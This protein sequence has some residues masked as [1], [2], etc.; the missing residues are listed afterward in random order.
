MVWS[1][2]DD[3][4]KL[5]KVFE[6]EVFMLCLI[7]IQYVIDWALSDIRIIRIF[8]LNYI[9]WEW[10]F[11]DVFVCCMCVIEC[12]VVLMYFPLDYLI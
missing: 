12:D 1:I 2:C 10:T 9:K 4:E 8:I 7:L 11:E 6:N 3:F 5:E